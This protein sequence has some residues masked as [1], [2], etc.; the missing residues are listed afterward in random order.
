[1]KIKVLMS[2]LLAFTAFGAF[3]QKGELKTANEEYI[4]YDGLRSANI[5]LAKP[6][7]MNAKT[8]IDKASANQKTANLPETFA[9]KAAIYGAL[10]LNETDPAAGATEYTTGLEASKKAAELDTKKENT[11][12]IDQA[13]AELAQYQLNKGVVDFQNK[14]YDQAYT[15]FEASRVLKPEDTLTV[16]YSAISASSA[17]K[18]PEA[19]TNYNKLLTLNYNRKAD[20]Y[21]DL[22]ALYMS[23]KDTTN[24][25]KVIGE[26]VSKFPTNNNLRSREIEISLMSGHTSDVIS[27]IDEA[28][29]ADPN[30]KNLYFYEGFTYSQIAEAA[31]NNLKKAQKNKL[32]PAQITKL[33]QTRLDAFTKAAE[34][35]KKAIAIDPN[36]FDAT[37]ALGYVLLTPGIDLYN[38]AVN[39]PVNETKQYNDAMAKANAQFEVAKPYLTKAVELNPQS[40]DALINLKQYYLG[41]KDME[42][43][44]AIQ[45]KI[46]ALPKVNK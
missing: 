31:G 6:S 23:N 1:M 16:L 24:A 45:K 12:M 15:E 5:A 13:N 20:V 8:A 40:Q 27:K 9:L 26:G 44:N 28:I 2:A 18:Y 10:A 21:N 4:K 36:Y 25:L 30:N 7:L 29:K 22:A 38:E 33:K 35:Y 17:K 43:A 14:K 19:I 39:L 41:K 42:N 37:M 11:K 46:D 32:T 34:Q 3:A